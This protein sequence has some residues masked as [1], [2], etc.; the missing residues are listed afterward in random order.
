M[1]RILLTEDQAMVRQG[2]KMMIETDSEMI[3]TGEASNGKEALE[4]CER[5]TFDIIILDIRM[6]EMNGLDAARVIRSRWPQSKVLML[7]T[8][9]DYQ[10]AMEALKIGAN[11]YMLKDADSEALIR[12]IRSCLSGGLSLQEEVAAKVI[13]Q[14]LKQT[15]VTSVDPSITPRELVIIRLVGEGRSNQEIANELALSLGTVKNHVSQI[16]DKLELRDR[17]QLAIYAIR[18]NVV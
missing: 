13:P 1:I 6:P 14:L 2:L 7:T 4:L 18:H 16:M 11:G 8:F 17:T 10:Y 3:V 12:S 15:A 9:N 5:N